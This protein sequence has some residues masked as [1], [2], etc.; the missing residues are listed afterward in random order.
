MSILPQSRRSR[1]FDLEIQNSFNGQGSELRTD[2][3]LKHVWTL[4]GLNLIPDRAKGPGYFIAHLTMV[5]TELQQ[6]QD[7]QIIEGTAEQTLIIRV[8]G[9]EIPLLSGLLG[10]EITTTEWVNNRVTQLGQCL[11]RI[12][13][14]ET[15]IESLELENRNLKQTIFDSRGRF[16]S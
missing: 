5:R 16:A 13:K 7:N 2:F 3:L 8:K 9:N 4:S 12:Q 14:L 15:E 11:E 6:S 10:S 1:E